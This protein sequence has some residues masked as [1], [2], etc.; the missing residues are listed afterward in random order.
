MGVICGVAIIFIFVEE[1]LIRKI[2]VDMKLILKKK[3]IYIY[4]II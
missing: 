3:K 1:E 2:Y 4:I